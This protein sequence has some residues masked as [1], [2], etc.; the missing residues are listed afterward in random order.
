MITKS[1]LL[2]GYALRTSHNRDKATKTYHNVHEDCDSR[3]QRGYYCI[4]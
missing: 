3:L 1:R 2:P 4:G